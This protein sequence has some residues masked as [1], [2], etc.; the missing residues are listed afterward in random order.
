MKLNIALMAGGNS[1][2]REVSL[3]SAQ[4]VEQSLDTGKYN[5][6]KIDL[7]GRSWS[8]EAPGGRRHEVDKNDFSLTVDG[9]RIALDY[10]L[11]LIHGTPGEDGK[12]QG[13]LDMMNIPY[14]SCDL[15]S[16]V[17]TFDKA[18]CKRTV[19]GTGV[20]LARE[21]FVRRG[22]RVDIDGVIAQLGLPLFVK[23]NASGSSCGVTK[24]RS[25][26]G[27]EPALKAAFAESDAVLIE[28]F[29]QGRE[30]ACGIMNAGGRY[31][32]F[33][34]TEVIPKNDFFDY[35][36]KYTSGMSTE[37]TPAEI[38]P[39]LKAKLGDATLEAY[40]AC[41][42]RGVVRVDFIVRDGE[43]YLVEI[44]SVPGMSAGGGIIP[45]QAAAM[46]MSLGTLFDLLI[47]ETRDAR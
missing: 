10:A 20:G 36:A 37:I 18:A 7:H 3:R 4:N 25:R 9:K 34:V 27:M 21:V 45:Q 43:P 29:I 11:I 13:Y 33:P 2:E 35:E 42:C 17:L 12:L 40:R 16:C 26:E 32:I 41:G 22:E 14:S 44:N 28:E 24:V 47:E 23:P 46:G 5:V 6:Y 39:V 1:S 19:A 30:M 38:N 8:Y 31:Y 15:A